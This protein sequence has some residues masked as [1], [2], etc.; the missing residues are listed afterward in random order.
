MIFSVGQLVTGKIQK[1]DKKQFLNEIIEFKTNVEI[2]SEVKDLIALYP[3]FMLAQL[4]QA[5]KESMH[6]FNLVVLFPEL[7]HLRDLFIDKNN[8]DISLKKLIQNTENT[9]QCIE[10]KEKIEDTKEENNITPFENKEDVSLDELIDK[11]NTNHPK[12]S[13]VFEDSEEDQEYEDLCKNSV[14]KKMNIVSETLANI[15]REQGNYDNAIKIYK[16]LMIRYPEKSSTF[17]HLITELKEK[18]NSQKN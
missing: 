15:Y 4:I 13:C 6:L 12:I 3:Y 7:Q 14:A 18:K 5:K 9:Q 2:P 10:E 11:F 1:M 8:E 16:A 17:A